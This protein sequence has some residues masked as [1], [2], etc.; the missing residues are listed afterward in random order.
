MLMEALKY[1]VCFSYIEN[2][3][4]SNFCYCKRFQQENS[5]E[6]KFKLRFISQNSTPTFSLFQSY[7]FYAPFFNPKW[8]N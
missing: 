3:K 8:G 4:K 2:F 1:S 5:L 6:S 7:S